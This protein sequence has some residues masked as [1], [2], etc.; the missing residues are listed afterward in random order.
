MQKPPSMSDEECM[1]LPVYA[2][3]DGFISKW[4]LNKEELEEIAR[5]GEIYFMVYSAVHPPICPMVESPFE[6]DYVK[7]GDRVQATVLIPGQSK[8]TEVEGPVEDDHGLLI[9]NHNG[10]KV[11]FYKCKNVYFLNRD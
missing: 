1:P 11:P 3:E 7:A 5:T 4:K 9:I 10:I 8:E 6:G 2:C